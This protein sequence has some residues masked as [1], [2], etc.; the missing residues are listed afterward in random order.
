MARNST[1]EARINEATGALHLTFDNGE[2]I[3]L[4]VDEL[5]PA[6]R[7]MA[8][9]HGLKQKLVDAA[10]ISRDPETGRSATTDDKY[11][12]V[13]AVY[14][15]LTG[16]NP[17]WNSVRGEGSGTGT[18]G[19]LFAA[20]VR[21][22]PAKTP[23]VLRDYLS[24]LTLAQQAALRKNPRVAP[25]IEEIKAERAAAGG[26]DDEPGADLLAGLEELTVFTLKANAQRDRAQAMLS[27]ELDDGGDA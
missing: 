3:S 4:S 16:P 8:M 2:R 1:I 24:G 23:D 22:Y 21:L 7:T 17:S 19:L 20:L 15:R 9:L 27:G 26:D 25:V 11:R 10:A 18:G 5:T 14:D 6:M 13:K 12:A